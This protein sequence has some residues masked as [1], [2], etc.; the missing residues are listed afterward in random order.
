[1]Q[2][3][4]NQN[5]FDIALQEFGTLE[6]LFTEILVPNKIDLDE[7]IKPDRDVKLNALGKGEDDIKGKIQEQGLIFSNNEVEKELDLIWIL[8][9]GI[10]NDSGI[11][12]DTELWID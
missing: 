6:N 7:E 11:W 3:K 9:Q 10:W 5:I 12:I 2:V 8:D 4:N 1:M